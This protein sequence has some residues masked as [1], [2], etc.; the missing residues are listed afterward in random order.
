MDA[1][2]DNYS[3]NSGYLCLSSGHA[4]FSGRENESLRVWI[5]QTELAFRARPWNDA[6]R[7]VAA[8]QCLSGAAARWFLNYQDEAGRADS[9]LVEITTWTQLRA[10]L[11]QEYRTPQNASNVRVTLDGL[12][13]S[14][15]KG[16]TLAEHV[17]TF[18]E[19]ISF[20]PRM[21][22]DEAVHRFTSTLPA[23]YQREIR[24]RNPVALTEAVTVAKAYHDSHCLPGGTPDTPSAHRRQ[25]GVV[26]MELDRMEGPRRGVPPHRS[27][28]IV[29]HTCGGPNHLARHC[30]ANAPFGG[31]QPW[32]QQTWHQP[33]QQQ[34]RQPQPYPPPMH[35]GRRA[36]TPRF[37]H[38][39]AAPVD[40]ADLYAHHYAEAYAQMMC[41]RG[42]YAVDGQEATP[43]EQDGQEEQEQEPRQGNEQ[44]Q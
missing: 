43:V 25:Q 6:Q 9:P 12:R 39:G 2:G 17:E 41:A 16:Q 40:E 8:A 24:H 37:G 28:G 3:N 34:P 11:E 21:A 20:L 31:H 19:L 22:S 4:R 23:D 29:C 15:E 5:L 44:R 7:F 13:W 27:G 42:A 33:Q 18:R 10:A 35:G 32:Q 38:L 26:P 30:T 14:K 36:R 1:Y